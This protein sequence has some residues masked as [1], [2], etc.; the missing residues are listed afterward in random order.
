MILIFF[1]SF[2]HLPPFI[3]TNISS[4]NF[5]KTASFFLLIANV[6]RIFFLFVAGQLKNS[7]NLFVNKLKK[8]K[9]AD[10]VLLTTIKRPSSLFLFAQRQ[11]LT[12]SIYGPI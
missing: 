12:R 8:L 2:L 10:G 6:Y 9:L 5:F 3:I 7:S 4:S 1:P 11:Y